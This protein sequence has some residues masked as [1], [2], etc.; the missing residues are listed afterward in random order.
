MKLTVSENQIYH[1]VV[2]T[3][4]IYP[5]KIRLFIYFRPMNIRKEGYEDYKINSANNTKRLTDIP[6]LEETIERSL[7]RSKR[8][9][10]DIVLCN[11]FD[12]FATFTF[13]SDRQNID[14]CK[15][16]MSKWLVNQKRIHGTFKYLIVPE[17]HKDK[18]SLHF[19][20]LFKGY[21]GRLK[22]SG[23]K[24]NG[25]IAYNLPGYTH[26]FSTVIKIDHIEKV[27]SYV[28][29]YITKDMPTFKGKKRYWVS[30]GLNRPLTLYNQ[31]FI[32]NPYINWSLKYIT[33]DF[34]ILEADDIT[35]LRQSNFKE[36]LLWQ[37]QT[38]M[39][40]ELSEQ[41]LQNASPLKQATLIP[42]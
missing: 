3:A 35:Y 8:L 13:K 7:R 2:E 42:L 39:Y 37:N 19:H 34:K 24:I 12:M 1:N 28:R 32:H 15:R 40:Q 29:K 27:S 10:S 21:S 11:D 5:N 23:K 30:T 41:S 31:G 14:L 16:R 26:G 4:K 17:F 9:I 36:K 6:S 38:L 20:A 33:N 22:D 25:R 18:K